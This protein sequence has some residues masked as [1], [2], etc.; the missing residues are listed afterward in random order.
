MCTEHSF[1]N[2]Y[3]GTGA[4]VMGRWQHTSYDYWP[5]PII[6]DGDTAEKYGNCLRM[7]KYA[8]LDPS[9][10]AMIDNGNS[11]NRNSRI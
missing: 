7:K 3:N 11:S 9:P 1:I 4:T 10:Q 8:T 2:S 5:V 6:N